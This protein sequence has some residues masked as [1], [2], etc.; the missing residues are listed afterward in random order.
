M[1]LDTKGGLAKYRLVRDASLDENMTLPMYF[2]S[3]SPVK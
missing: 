1:D 3:N 2:F